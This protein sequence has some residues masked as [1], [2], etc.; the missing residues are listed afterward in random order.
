MFAD[1][2][3]KYGKPLE[4]TMSFPMSLNEFDMLKASMRDGRNSD[5][6]L[7]IFKEDKVVVIAKPWYP[8]RLYRAPSGGIKPGEDIELTAS[9]EAYEETGASIELEKYILKIQVTFLYAQETIKWISHV[10]TAKYLSGDLRPIDKKEIKEVTLMS[11]NELSSLKPKL[12]AQDSG[13][14]AY[15]S[16]LTET[17][18]KE[19]L[20]AEQG[21]GM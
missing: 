2:E 3:K 8:K 4:L 16:A 1:I 11:L 9:R 10:F 20:S 17:A 19:I 15:R 14:L 5:V 12:L 7:F 21:K 13:G 6:T 18:I